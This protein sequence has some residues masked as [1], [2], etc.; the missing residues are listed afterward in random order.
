[1]QATSCGISQYMGATWIWWYISWNRDF[2]LGGYTWLNSKAQLTW[3]W[4]TQ[5]FEPNHELEYQ[6]PRT[7]LSVTSR[8]RDIEHP[9]DTLNMNLTVHVIVPNPKDSSQRD[10]SKQRYRTSS[11]LHPNMNLT[12]CNCTKHSRTLLSVT[13]RNRDIEHLV[14]YTWTWIWLHV[15]VPNIQGLFSAWHLET[16]IS[17]V[18]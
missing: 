4:V 2:Q 11:K 7:L 16:E 3:L 12:T 18:W 14:N 5:Y 15:I 17:N 1:M 8:N 9:V 13:S 6:T 10:I